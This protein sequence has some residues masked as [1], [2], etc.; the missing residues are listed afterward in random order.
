MNKILFIAAF[1]VLFVQSL[2]AQN[3]RP[4]TTVATGGWVRRE[5]IDG[6]TF[7]VASL[8]T[9]K[10]R[11]N[12]VFSNPSDRSKL[13]RYRRY[14]NNVRGYAEQAVALYDDLMEQKDEKSRR[15]YRKYA[16]QQKKLHKDELESKLKDLYVEEGKM[17]IKMVERQTGKPFYEILKESRGTVSATYWQ[18][19]SKVW[20]LNLK[21]GYIVGKDPIMDEV[22]LDFDYGDAIWRY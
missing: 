7:Y 8:N 6:D 10:V 21:E 11:S 19:M 16:R 13:H 2:A 4:D 5:I 9:V 3:G 12:R 1:A 15:Q 17:L 20:G 22:L 14:A 18:G